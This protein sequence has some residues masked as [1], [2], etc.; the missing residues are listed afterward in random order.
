MDVTASTTPLQRLAAPLQRLTISQKLGLGFGAVVFLM[1]CSLAF[2]GAGSTSLRLDSAVVGREI[3]PTMRSLGDASA[4]V[5][6]HRVL[7][8]ER[9]RATDP[10]KQ[11]QLDRE[12]A[13]VQRR[14]SADLSRLLS[15]DTT[16]TPT[17]RAGAAA[18]WQRY[19]RSADAFVA[20]LGDGPGSAD[21]VLDRQGSV[22]YVGLIR[23]LAMWSDVLSKR[24]DAVAAT[25]SAD[26][27]A[28]QTELVVALLAAVGVALLAAGLLSRS[29]HLRVGEVLACL[30]SLRDRCAARLD[31]GLRAFA[32]GD[33]TREVVIS[34][35]PIPAPGADEIGDVAR[36]TNTIRDRFEAMIAAYNTSRGALAG[37]IGELSQTAGDV[38][39][40]SQHVA[41]SSDE[42]GRAIQ[43]IA[44]AMSSAAEGT[45][46]Q[47]AT[48]AEARA[49]VDE[50]VQVTGRSAQ[51]A[52]STARVARD[53][54][55]IASDGADAIVEATDAMALVREASAAATKAIS[56]L[57]DRSAE[58]GGIVEAIKG[59]AEQTNL[60]AL[61]AAI[62]AA[63]A[64]E[65]GRG[66][67][68]VADEVRKLAV[69][70]Q[71]AAR[72]IADLVIGIQSETARVVEVVQEGAERTDKGTQVVEGARAAF[73]R[74]GTSVEEVTGRV[75]VIAAAVEQ[76]AASAQEV[77]TRMTE[78]ASVAERSSASAERVSA[79]TE[80]T[81]ASTEEIAASAQE[82]ARTASELDSLVARFKV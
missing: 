50:V 14:L 68:V 34:T 36:A 32:N 58:I 8:L 69:E 43:G 39:S 15:A 45:A 27:T 66:F 51:D 20:A 64:G 10:A 54:R 73:H 56:A 60:L 80:Q 55:S 9:A 25:A 78:V 26:A 79:S 13:A 81:S 44:T 11:R 29:L 17:R 59:I 46:L 67:A 57:G 28:V 4:A 41:S 72:S 77:G 65:H 82:L 76:I 2:A 23:D 38:S 71:T 63:R 3:V 42:A 70:S 61:N 37:L 6:Q 5:R 12:L 74:I 40:A 16:L 47:V 75:G 22:A 18:A 35:P 30:S 52:A 21:A 62:E 7:E 33:L 19:Q 49:I 24:G 1:L 31:E 48:V 53:A